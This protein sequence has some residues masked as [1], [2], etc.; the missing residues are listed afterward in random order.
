MKM[1][2]LIAAALV[3]PAFLSLAQSVGAEDMN[4]MKKLNITM[5]PATTPADKAFAAS[6][7]TMMNGM[8]VKPTGKPDTDF[9]LMMMPHHQGAIDMAKVELQYGTDP[10]LRQLATDIVAAQQKE[11]T[12]MKD[13]LAKNGK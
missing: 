9:V 5:K 8:N 6:M 10:E 2:M 4:N 7:K 3:M 12:Q 1:S 13:W 11:I